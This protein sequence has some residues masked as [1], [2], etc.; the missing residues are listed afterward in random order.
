[1]HYGSSIEDKSCEGSSS[2]RYVSRFRSSASS[3]PSKRLWRREEEQIYQVHNHVVPKTEL[4]KCACELAV[5]LSSAECSTN[6]LRLHWVLHAYTQCH[7]YATH[8]IIVVL[9]LLL[10]IC[11]LWLSHTIRVKPTGIWDRPSGI[12]RH[13]LMIGYCTSTASTL[14]DISCAA[15]RDLRCY[16]VTNTV[17]HNAMTS[18]KNLGLLD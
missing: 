2:L 16:M 4:S 13:W 3:R 18:G 11:L 6:S 17:L 12:V 7:N 1:M 9:W 14:T 5:W 8:I 15:V 10:S